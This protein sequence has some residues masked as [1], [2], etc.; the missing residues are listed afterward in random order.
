MNNTN[1]LFET[2]VENQKKAVD[3]FLETTSKF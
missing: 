3:T 1:E 2:M